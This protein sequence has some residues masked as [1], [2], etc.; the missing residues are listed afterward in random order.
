LVPQLPYSPDLAPVDI[1]LFPTLKLH[2]KIFRFRLL[3]EVQQKAL[4]QLTQSSSKSY[5]ECWEK[6][7]LH[8]D[9]YNSARGAILKG[10]VFNK[11]CLL[12]IVFYVISLRKLRASKGIIKRT[13]PR[14][15]C[16]VH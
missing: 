3:K 9:R 4:G 15:Y 14:L 6:W 16:M 10:T 11:I 2:L 12:R 5:I 8:W 13:I 7:K 1:L